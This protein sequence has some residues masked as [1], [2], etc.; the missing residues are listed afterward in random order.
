MDDIEEGV[1]RTRAPCTVFLCA[2]LD[3][4]KTVFKFPS[5]ELS[6]ALTCAV[7]TL[8]KSFQS[9]E[10]Q[11]DPM[12]LTAAVNAVLVNSPYNIRTSPQKKK[13]RC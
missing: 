1:S 12:S 3:S 5:L 4:P 10:G 11:E 7:E 9:P 13:K 8:Q 6:S 2:A